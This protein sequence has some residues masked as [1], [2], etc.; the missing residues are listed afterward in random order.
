MIDEEKIS[1]DKISKIWH[2]YM[3][4]GDMPDFLHAPWYSSKRLR[5]F[6]LHLPAEPRCRICFY[7]F[8]G[9]G[10]KIMRR[11]FGITPSKLNPH[12]CNQC[13]QFLEAY[14]GG[15]EIDLTILF[16]DVRGS[17]RLAEEM[18]PTEFSRL[19]NRFYNVTAKVLFDSGAMVE[20][21]IGDA[22]TAFYTPG[23]GG[24]DHARI[25]IDAARSILK[26]TGHQLPSGAWIPVGIGIHS[27][28]AYVGSVGSESGVNDIVVLGDTANTGA[29][30][31]S[32]AKPGEILV[33][34]DAASQAGLDVAGVE[35]R[36]LQLKG[37]SEPVEAWVLEAR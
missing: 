22:V 32:L 34:R 7:P 36:H 27:G 30:L 13:E 10:G 18:S 6:Y 31:A 3:T 1:S 5:P 26:A 37:R 8:K 20:K 4:T 17:T 23:F 12:L 21:L 2:T 15:A 16:A 35:T 29:R 11:V 14:P 9:L 24:Y 19:I 33:S 28:K 25:A